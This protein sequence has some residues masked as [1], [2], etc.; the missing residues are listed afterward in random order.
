MIQLTFNI[1][2]SINFDSNMMPRSVGEKLQDRITISF[3]PL[4]KRDMEIALKNKEFTNVANL[5]NTALRF[6]FDNRFR[7]SN[8]IVKT[9]KINTNSKSAKEIRIR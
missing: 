7:P 8:D 4:N 1:F 6:Y 9:N 2:N 3:S 5:V